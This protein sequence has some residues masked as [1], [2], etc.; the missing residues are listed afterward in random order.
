MLKKVSVIPTDNFNKGLVTH[1]NLFK[2]LPGQSPECLNVQFNIDTSISKRLGTSTMN[3]VALQS[4]GG[5]GM[6]DFGVNDINPSLLLHFDDGQGGTSITDSSPNNFTVLATGNA[7]TTSA[8]S[9]F[10]NFSLVLT[11]T[12]DFLE[13]KDSADWDFED[14]DFSLDSRVRLNNYPLTSSMSTILSQGDKNDNYWRLGLRESSGSYNWH[15]RCDSGGTTMIDVEKTATLGTAAWYHLAFVRSGNDFMF[16]QAGSQVGTAVSNTAS[17]HNISAPLRVGA[18]NIDDIGTLLLLHCDGPDKSTTF[19]DS[20]SSNNIL[21]GKGNVQIDTAQSVFGD[22]SALFDGTGDYINIGT[23]SIFEVAGDFTFESR[24]RLASLPAGNATILGTTG[25]SINVVAQA[26]QL[27]VKLEA[28]TKTFAWVPGTATWYHLAVV[29]AS[30]NLSVYIEG[31]Q[32]GATVIST[33][34]IAS[35]STANI[36]ATFNAVEGWDGWLDEIRFSNVA[37]WTANFTSPTIAYSNSGNGFDGWLD[38]LRVSNGIAR[39]TTAFTPPTEA[40]PGTE[41]TVNRLIVSAGTGIYYSSDLG[42]TFSVCHTSRT[43]TLNHFSFIK[44]YAINTNDEYQDPLFWTGTANTSFEPIAVDSAPKCKYSSASQGFAFLLNERGKKRNVYYIDENEIFSAASWSTF[45]LPTSR[46]DELTGGFELNRKFYISSKSKIYRLGYI[47]G[48]PDWDYKQVKNWGFV[49]ETV[50]IVQIPGIPTDVA[51]GLDWS[52]R[53]HVFDGNNDEIISSEVE[54]NNGLTPFYMQNI[55]TENIQKCWAEDDRGKQVYRLHVP[56]DDSPT[57]NREIVYNYRNNSLYPNDNR[58]FQS[59][60][61]ATDTSN[62]LHMLVCDYSGYV[63]HIDSGNRDITQP[64][65][66]YYTSPFLFRKNP[67]ISQ[68][69]QKM[70]MHFNPTSSGTIHYEDRLDW[71]NVWNPCKQFDLVS[72]LSAVQTSKTIDLI[73]VNNVYQ[74]KITS[75]SNTADPWR[76]NR[77]DYFLTD[78]GIGRP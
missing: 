64:V 14:A 71:S 40:Y 47:G 20:S 51:I 35:V 6:Y 76:L 66:D 15:F 23:S 36:G 74:Y 55:N 9:V 32:I 12:N 31:S 73:N 77:A 29:R 33:E 68:K 46:N 39:W 41:N 34:T 4:T 37:R 65:N 58:P 52:K 8:Q 26:A 3:T 61:L 59:G 63:H 67:S 44:K 7:Q 50:K 19:L 60:I 11:A 10:G 48:N 30:T 13:I 75:S 43:A 54:E 5:Y 16:F 18:S 21:T 56:Y 49:P 72:E 57:V 27:L 53:L 62:G 28:A 2:L 1:Q 78:L 42:K 17:V 38:E 22:A 25:E 69:S 24:I 45:E 70:A